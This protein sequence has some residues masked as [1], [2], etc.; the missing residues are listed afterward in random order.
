MFLERNMVQYLPYE[1]KINLMKFTINSIVQKKL[2]FNFQFAATVCNQVGN[3][4][5]HQ[6]QNISNYRIWPN[7]VCKKK[8][9]DTLVEVEYTTEDGQRPERSG[10]DAFF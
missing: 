9:I 4:K 1:K 10:S 2:P 3:K 7:A 6:Y 8:Y 5:L